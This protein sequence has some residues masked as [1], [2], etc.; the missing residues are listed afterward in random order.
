MARL[1]ACFPNESFI[2]SDTAGKIFRRAEKMRLILK[3]GE[4]AKLR[5]FVLVAPFLRP[6][7]VAVYPLC[8]HGNSR[9]VNAPF[10]FFAA[11]A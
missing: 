1:V 2:G 3:K 6:H 4:R 11:T 7:F 10:A 9:A 8:M 5:A